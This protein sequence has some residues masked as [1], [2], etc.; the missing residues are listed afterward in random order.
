MPLMNQEGMKRFITYIV[1]LSG[2]SMADV[3]QLQKWFESTEWASG[4]GFYAGQKVGLGLPLLCHRRGRKRVEFE[5]CPQPNNN[6][7]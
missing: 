6:G 4:L 7:V 2:G 5:S 3:K 1:R